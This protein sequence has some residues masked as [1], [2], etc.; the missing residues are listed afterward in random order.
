MMGKFDSKNR[1][2]K[3]EK[4]KKHVKNVK[5]F[6]LRRAKQKQREEN[7]DLNWCA[8]KI[9]ARRAAKIFGVKKRYI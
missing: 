2:S 3:G 5:I 9:A 6:R 7:I 1:I 8:K 4:M